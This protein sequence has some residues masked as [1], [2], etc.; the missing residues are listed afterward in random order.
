[1]ILIMELLSDF[2]T[3]NRSASRNS[4][5]AGALPGASKTYLILID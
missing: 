5:A 1:M 4:L 3:T 2:Y